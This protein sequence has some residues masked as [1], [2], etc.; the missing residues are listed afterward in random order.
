MDRC[1]VD[2]GYTEIDLSHSDE[3]EVTGLLP[4]VT[5]DFRIVSSEY[6]ERSG[7]FLYNG[8][9][10]EQSLRD[11]PIILM[12][13]TRYV[14]EL[15]YLFVTASD[16]MKPF[17]SLLWGVLLFTTTNLALLHA[18]LLVVHQPESE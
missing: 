2:I 3:D 14:P 8:I 10:A 15:K 5:E 4:I 17:M 1:L 18:F 11:L 16:C 12:L 7:P 13:R 6:A 9:Q